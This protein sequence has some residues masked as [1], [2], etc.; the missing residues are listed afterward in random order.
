MA[1][2]PADMRD[3]QGNITLAM[4]PQDSDASLNTKLQAYLDRG[5]ALA[6]VALPSAAAA[7]LDLAAMAWAYHISYAAIANRL[8]AEYSSKS[9]QDLGSTG[10]SSKQIEHYEKLAAD[11]LAQFTEITTPVSVGGALPR[12]T[13]TTRNYVTWF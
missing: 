10:I 13:E 9:L 11:A 7:T 2:G 8:A 1:K 5:Y 4:F 12:A 6:G 3:P